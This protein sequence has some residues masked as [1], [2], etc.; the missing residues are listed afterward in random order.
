MMTISEDV[1][2][3]AIKVTGTLPPSFVALL[4][5][6]LI[7]ILGM[8]WFMHDLAITRIEAVMKLFSVC[9]TALTGMK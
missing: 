8:L 9:T 5:I 2:D 6:N 3:V 1:R 7:F 4:C